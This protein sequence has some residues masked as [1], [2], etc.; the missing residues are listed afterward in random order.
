MRLLWGL[1]QFVTSHS[2]HSFGNSLT[3]LLKCWWTKWSQFV[4]SLQVLLTEHV[5]PLLPSKPQS[6]TARFLVLSSGHHRGAVWHCLKHQAGHVSPNS[7]FSS[8]FLQSL[9][10]LDNKA[11]GCCHCLIFYPKTCPGMLPQTMWN[12][13]FLEVVANENDCCTADWPPMVRS[14]YT[15]Q[16]VCSSD[17]EALPKQVFQKCTNFCKPQLS[18]SASL[19]DCD[20]KSPV[21]VNAAV[22]L[23]WCTHA[24]STRNQCF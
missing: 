18:M 24:P 8:I 15:A 4:L 9:N 1:W 22:H 13:L 23:C 7:A 17:A 11:A 20:V 10:H 3:L 2:R 12:I 14:Q 21:H 5:K 19:F 6:K 16:Q